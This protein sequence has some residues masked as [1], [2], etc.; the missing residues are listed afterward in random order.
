MFSERDQWEEIDIDG[1]DIATEDRLLSE[2]VQVQQMHF[3]AN[4]LQTFYSRVNALENILNSQQFLKSHTIVPADVTVK[5][6]QFFKRQHY[7]NVKWNGGWPSDP[8]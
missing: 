3:V 5:V 6:V 8:S 2:L 4:P 1:Q 7:T